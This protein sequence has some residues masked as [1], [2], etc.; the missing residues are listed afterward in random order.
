MYINY[1]NKLLLYKRDSVKQDLNM[2]NPKLSFF[3]S[4][5]KKDLSS[6]RNRGPE[7]FVGELLAD[8]SS[9]DAEPSDKEPRLML[10]SVESRPVEDRS[11]VGVVAGVDSF[12][13][14]HIMS[15]RS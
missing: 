2:L 12:D 6:N 8:K 15:A 9:V 3:S 7:D 1:A 5:Q 11:S 10:R 14:L 4:H 13:M